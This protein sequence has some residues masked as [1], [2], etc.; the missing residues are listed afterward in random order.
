MY[1]VKVL[2]KW[3]LSLLAPHNNDPSASIGIGVGVSVLVVAFIVWIVLVVWR[4]K[5]T[6]RALF[7]NTAAISYFG[8]AAGYQATG[9]GYVAA[10]YQS[11]PHPQTI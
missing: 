10:G 4:R 7:L 2:I 3:N 6:R 8:P 5:N 11:K 9:S 1:C